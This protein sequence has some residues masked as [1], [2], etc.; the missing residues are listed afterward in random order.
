[1]SLPSQKSVKPT[2]SHILDN[3][4][5]TCAW[6]STF[7]TFATTPTTNLGAYCT[8]P[9]N[10]IPG[11][12][13]LP[14]T[15]HILPLPSFTCHKPQMVAHTLFPQ[16]YT[17][18]LADPDAWPD[19]EADFGLKLALG[20]A[21]VAVLVR[22]LW[23]RT[24]GVACP[25]VAF[26]G[27]DSSTIEPLREAARLACALPARECSS[28]RLLPSA[29]TARHEGQ[30][31]APKFSTCSACEPQNAPPHP[32]QCRLGSSRPNRA[33]HPAAMQLLTLSG[34]CRALLSGRDHWYRTCLPRRSIGSKP[35]YSVSLPVS[36]A[37][38]L[39]LTQ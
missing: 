36:V 17:A 16:L 35:T 8:P 2:S 27:A 29:S 39:R 15:Y 28:P 9:W 12:I 24:G 37:L 10:H 1:M 33:L 25:L 14:F 13:T 21:A 31:R 7:A 22:G 18:G 23:P 6:W 34:T 19:A 4:N 3:E 20:E 38:V 30:Y 32:P 26:T 11:V 5:E